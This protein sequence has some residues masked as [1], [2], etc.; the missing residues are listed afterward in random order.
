MQGGID[1]V[2]DIVGFGSGNPERRSSRIGFTI[3]AVMVAIYTLK[4]A[5]PNVQKR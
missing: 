2:I 4:M 3:A 5:T 1:V